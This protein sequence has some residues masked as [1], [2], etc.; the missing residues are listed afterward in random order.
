MRWDPLRGS[1]V[2]GAE[3]EGAWQKQDPGLE[4]LKETLDA[5]QQIQW[6]IKQV[7]PLAAAP[8]LGGPQA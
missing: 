1:G 7:C 8:E 4:S 5:F 2:G 6:I 3:E